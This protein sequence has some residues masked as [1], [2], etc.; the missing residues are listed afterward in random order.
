ML[1]Q[2]ISVE[3]N[4]T[5]SRGNCRRLTDLFRVLLTIKMRIPS[6][7]TRVSGSLSQDI[8]PS[9]LSHPVAELM[10]RLKTSQ[11][12]MSGVGLQLWCKGT[13]PG[14]YIYIYRFLASLCI[15]TAS[16]QCVKSLATSKIHCVC[17]ITTQSTMREE[18]GYIKGLRLTVYVQ[19][20]PS[21]PCVKSL[22]TSKG[23]IVYVQ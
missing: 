9:D 16:G 17:T 6:I 13:S 22:V 5:F 7:L 15:Y 18:S 11:L 8:T 1:P 3:W 12:I 10:I 14:T 21:Q 19:L 2:V 4:W 20:T 23:Y